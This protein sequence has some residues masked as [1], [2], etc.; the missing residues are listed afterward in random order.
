MHVKGLKWGIFLVLLPAF[1][2]CQSNSD[3]DKQT[4]RLKELSVDIPKDSLMTLAPTMLNLPNYLQSIEEP[5]LRYIIYFD[6]ANCATCKLNQLGTWRPI[7]KNARDIGVKVNF[8]F[9][10][11]PASNMIQPFRTHYYDRR[12]C[13][14]VYLDTTGVVERLNPFIKESSVFHRFVINKDNHI[15]VIGDAGDNM[16]EETRFYDYLRRYVQKRDSSTTNR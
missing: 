9:I 1:I 2:S 4:Q 3:I 6:S 14:Y 16:K 12:N 15:E 10:F 5:E 8:E 11:H 7:I 13:F